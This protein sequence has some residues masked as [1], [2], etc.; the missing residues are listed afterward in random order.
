MLLIASSAVLLALAVVQ[1]ILAWRVR[2]NVPA[3]S[4]LPTPPPASQWPRVSIVVPARNESFGIEAALASK[5]SC[6]YPNLEVVVVDDRSTDDTGALAAAFARKDPRVRVARIDE[7]P[8][9]WLGKLHAMT[10]GAE[11]ATGEFVLFSDADVHVN[12]GTLERVVAYAE[13]EAI[14]MV[15]LMPQTHPVGAVIDAFVAVFV[16]FSAVGL[17]L[18]AANDPTSN[19]GMGVGAFNLVRKRALDASPGFSHLRMEVSDDVALGAMMKASGARCRFL[20]GREDVHLVFVERIAVAAR[21]LEKGGH[22]FDFSLFRAIAVPTVVL[23]VELGIG[24]YAITQGGLA[25]ALGATQLAAVTMVYLVLARHFRAPL[26][27]AIL[28][29]IGVVVAAALAMRAGIL[30]WW[31]G[32]IEWRGTRYDRSTIT[33]GRRFVRGTVRLPK[34]PLQVVS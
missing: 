3:L 6:G 23:A 18:W 12:P 19:V 22:M 10:V 34:T 9:G 7:L 17:R 31:R 13:S 20:A 33:A 28:W 5:L 8:N 16:R 4:T 29:P 11:N 25:A 21:N 32:G 15:A 27:G 24:I 2:T 1:V 30:G 14:D 26:R